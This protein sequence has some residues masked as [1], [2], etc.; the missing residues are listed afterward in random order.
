MPEI[1]PTVHVDD[2]HALRLKLVSE[3]RLPVIASAKNLETIGAA[4]HLPTFCD[5]AST[6]NRLTERV[7][8]ARSTDRLLIVLP[9][10]AA[11]Y[12]EWNIPT[13]QIDFASREAETDVPAALDLAAGTVIEIRVDGE[14]RNVVVSTQYTGQRRYDRMI[15]Y[16]RAVT[17]ANLAP[18]YC[19]TSTTERLGA[20][21][22]NYVGTITS[23]VFHA[24]A[25]PSDLVQVCRQPETR[26]MTLII[27]PLSWFARMVFRTDAN[28]LGWVL[29]RDSIKR[30]ISQRST[31]PL[32]VSCERNS[33]GH[34]VISVTA[35]NERDVAISLSDCAVLTSAIGD[36]LRASGWTY[37]DRPGGGWVHVREA[38]RR[39]PR[40]FRRV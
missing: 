1:F 17:N 25:K 35:K 37:I 15:T 32:T 27:E 14:Y 33:E 28:N 40:G 30:F 4:E 24:H 9:N 22:R 8:L 2:L 36:A 31:V 16:T 39:A 21:Y 19:A 12:A 29:S 23:A 20:N 11:N 38:N 34:V 26:D 10:I 3:S 7:Q 13:Y 6:S 5:L 18:S